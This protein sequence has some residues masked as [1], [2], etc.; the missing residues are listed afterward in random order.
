MKFGLYSYENSRN[1]L[2]LL[3]QLQY[4]ILHKMYSKSMIYAFYGQII[5]PL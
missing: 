2:Y 3:A 1:A 5:I 4:F